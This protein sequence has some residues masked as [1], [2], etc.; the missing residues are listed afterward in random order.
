M[1][2]TDLK[3]YIGKQI[4]ENRGLYIA[5]VF[6]LCVGIVLGSYCV[7]HIGQYQKSS[8]TDY[9]NNFIKSY[10][11]DYSDG[12]FI[13]FEAFKNYLPFIMAIWFLGLTVIGIPIILG[14]DFVKGFTIGFTGSFLYNASGNKGILMILLCIIPQN[15]IY[16]ICIIAASAIAVQFS[17]M[18]IKDTHN[19]MYSGK[20]ILHL[21]AIYSG[22]FIGLF[23]IMLVGF[24]IEAYFTPLMMRFF[25]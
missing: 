18:L 10:H 13:F 1:R 3:L 25:V 16:I 14:I 20:N 7:T 8:L 9:F 6:C 4:H 24:L 5:C 22:I 19:S 17:I 11:S 12:K 21:T 2:A 15:I 23:I